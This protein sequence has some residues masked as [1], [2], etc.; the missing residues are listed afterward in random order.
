[1]KLTMV[2]LLLDSRL[3]LALPRKVRLLFLSKLSNSYPSLFLYQQ[4]DG[5]DDSFMGYEAA[6]AGVGSSDEMAVINRIFPRGD[7]LFHRARLN[8]MFKR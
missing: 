4:D 8:R 5:V 3:Y 2:T 7:W 1:M 6:W